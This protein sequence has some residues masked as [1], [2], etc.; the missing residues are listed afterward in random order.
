MA[1]PVSVHRR[2]NLL[3]SVFNFIGINVDTTTFTYL[4]PLTYRYTM[5]VAMG[6]L[7][8]CQVNRAIIFNYGILSTDFSG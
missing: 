5:W 4:P 6:Y 1:S 7:T 2:A 8:L 3:Q